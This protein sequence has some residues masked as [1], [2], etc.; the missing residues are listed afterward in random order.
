MADSNTLHIRNYFQQSLNAVVTDSNWN[1]CDAPKRGVQ[2]GNIAANQQS[3]VGFC[4]TDG[5]GCDG[6]QGEFEIAFN[7][8]YY[9]DLNFDSNGNIGISSPP[10]NFFA[11]LSQVPGGTYT[12]VVGP[13]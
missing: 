13:Q 11:L 1:C 4:R 6:E 7:S 8:T 2:I 12:L 10:T 5:H 9:V 3:D